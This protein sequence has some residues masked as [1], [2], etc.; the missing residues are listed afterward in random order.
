MPT[1]HSER[2][3][4][5]IGLPGGLTW[6]RAGSEPSLEAFQATL[7]PTALIMRGRATLTY[8]LGRSPAPAGS[9]GGRR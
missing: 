7:G 9:F 1:D 2:F 8:A 3:G 4:G 5:Q 6:K